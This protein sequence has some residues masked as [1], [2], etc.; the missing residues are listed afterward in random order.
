MLYEGGEMCVKRDEVM[1][2]SYI[3]LPCKQMKTL[4]YPDA[5][6]LKLYVRDPPLWKI[7]ILFLFG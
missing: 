2:E 7:S 3:F 1:D 6:I 5:F 4:K